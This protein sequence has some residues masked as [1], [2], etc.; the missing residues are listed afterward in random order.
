MKRILAAVDGSE[1]ALRALDFAAK[2][3]S[4]TQAELVIL[5]VAEE[6]YA[7]GGALE[8]FA[9][10]EHLGSAWGDL[11]EAG[12]KQILGTAE[13]RVASCQGLRRRTEWRMGY[14]AGEIIRFAKEQACDLLVMGH[15]GRSRLLGVLLGSVAFKLVTLCP[16]PVTVV[17]PASRP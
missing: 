6:L 15:V 14:P 13:A 8:Q 7:G 16:C 2:L 11:R 17:G 9:R 1:A 3:A 10:S 12:A 5:T 4:G